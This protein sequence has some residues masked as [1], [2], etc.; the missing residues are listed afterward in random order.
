MKVKIH[1]VRNMNAEPNHWGNDFCDVCF[2]V[3]VLVTEDLACWVFA[4]V[5]FPS[6]HVLVMGR[7]QSALSSIC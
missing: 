2:L 5:L 4:S 7:F 1:P 6:L 3:I